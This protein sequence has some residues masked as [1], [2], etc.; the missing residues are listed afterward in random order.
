MFTKVSHGVKRTVLIVYVDDIIITGDDLL[1]MNNLK[2]SLA[3]EFET[4]DLGS[5]N[6]FLSME[7]A[8]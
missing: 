1:E 7:V 2:K 5:L 6:Y 4:K 8:R 3:S